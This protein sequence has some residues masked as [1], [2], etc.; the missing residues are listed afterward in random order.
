MNPLWR[1]KK[2]VHDSS[3]VCRPAA[4][5]ILFRAAYK[6]LIDTR[7]KILSGDGFRVVVCGDSERCSTRGS[8]VRALRERLA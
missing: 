6:L 3:T 5:V 7:E 4:A 1:Q 2:C 8:L